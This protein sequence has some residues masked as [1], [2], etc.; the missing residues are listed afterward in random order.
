MCEIGKNIMNLVSYKL[1]TKEAETNNIQNEW[2]YM[3][4]PDSGGYSFIMDSL[5]QCQLYWSH[6]MYFIEGTSQ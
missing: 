5:A 6:L 2:N 4:P 3:R 1:T